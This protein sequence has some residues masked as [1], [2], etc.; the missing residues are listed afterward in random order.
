MICISILDILVHNPVAEFSLDSIHL[1]HPAGLILFTIVL[2]V[3]ISNEI[4]IVTARH[5]W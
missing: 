5:H 3:T 1:F 4:I 2:F